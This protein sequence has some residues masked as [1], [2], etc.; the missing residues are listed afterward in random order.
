MSKGSSEKRDSHEQLAAITTE[1][2]ITKKKK[3]KI[4]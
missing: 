3:K 1:I 2:F 4:A